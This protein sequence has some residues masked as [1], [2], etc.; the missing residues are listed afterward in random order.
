MARNSERRRHDRAASPKEAKIACASEEWIAPGSDMFNLAVR[1][2][3]TSASGACLLTKGRLRAGI[4]VTVGIVLPNETKV[5]SK[6]VVRWATT[7]ES[8]GRVAHV[9][10]L[11]FEKPVADLAPS[12]P[13]L[14]PSEEPN[15]RHKRFVPDKVELV[16]LPPGILS[17][18]GVRSNAAKAL[19][20]LSLGGAQI[21]SSEKYKTGDRIDLMLTFAFPKTSL[22]A[23]GVVKWCRRDTISLEP[24]WNVGVV[25]KDMDP[26]AQSRLRTVEAVFADKPRK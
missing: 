3:D 13:R 1:L 20:D 8:K 5:L 15:R 24:R 9:A 21:V 16:C 7:V 17:K 23:T 11:E 19:K 22:R 26:S 25:F 18:I 10:G 2:L 6:A 14:A 12:L 4:P